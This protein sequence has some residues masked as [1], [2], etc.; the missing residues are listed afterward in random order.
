[1]REP[2]ATFGAFMHPD[3]S[4]IDLKG[5][6]FVDDDPEWLNKK[7][8]EVL[9]K[10]FT[11]QPPEIGF[12]CPGD[13]PSLFYLS[14]PL[15]SGDSFDENAYWKV[16]IEAVVKGWIKDMEAFH[17][18]SAERVQYYAGLRDILRSVVDLLD[19]TIKECQR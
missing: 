1:M 17:D 7:I 15:G 3:V 2:E 19:R 18:N 10:E 9:V 6:A 8:Q 13:D 11:E 5:W 16:P 14:L 4:G 12:A